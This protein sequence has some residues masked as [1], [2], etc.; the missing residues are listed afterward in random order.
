M[1]ALRLTLL[2]HSRVAGHCCT[3]KKPSQMSIDS[4]WLDSLEQNQRFIVYSKLKYA[5]G[6]AVFF[7]ALL[8]TQDED[9]LFMVSFSGSLVKTTGTKGCDCPDR[10]DDRVRTT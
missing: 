2:D 1:P 6:M 10:A 8:T 3:Y 4:H 9:H 5:S 7:K